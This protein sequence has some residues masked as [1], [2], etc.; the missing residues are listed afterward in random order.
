MGILKIKTNHTRNVIM[1]ANYIKHLSYSLLT[2][3]IFLAT[4]SSSFAAKPIELKFS[5]YLPTGHGLHRDFIQPWAEELEKR[6]QGKVKV[7]IFTG[8]SAL[9][10]ITRQAD[11]VKAGVVDISHGIHSIPRGRFPRTSIMHLPFM[12]KSADAISRTLWALYQQ[13]QFDKEYDGFKVLALHGHNAGLIHTKDKP[14]K[15]IA[16]MKG[17]RLR[18]PN[19]TVSLMLEHL[20]ATPVGMPPS[21][22]YESIQKGV[23]DGSLFP[24]DPVRAFHLDEVTNY[25]MNLKAYTT[26]FFVVM[27]MRKYKRLPADVR[28]VIDEMSG[29]SLVAK[30]GEWWNQWDAKG[31]EKA[32][33]KGNTIIEFSEDERQKFHSFVQPMIDARLAEMKKQ[34]VSDPEGLYKAAKTLINSL[35]K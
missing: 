25:H 27:N 6:T 32:V 9:G 17:L 13:G 2:G 34:G 18:T 23:L 24:W 4:Q 14:I 8:G 29:E 35:E 5:H 16:D 15:T 12:G 26:T 31:L 11:Q 22:V 28:K 10:K 1:P 33:E 20:G 30:F 19:P 21:V 3:V 7:K